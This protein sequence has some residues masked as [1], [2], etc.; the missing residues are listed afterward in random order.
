MKGGESDMEKEMIECYLDKDVTIV[1][2][3]K[4]SQFHPERPFFYSGNI[5][6]IGVSGLCFRDRYDGLTTFN[7]KDIAE[8]KEWKR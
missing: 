4:N 1:V 8:I 2:Y 7:M 3:Y 6:R 5:E